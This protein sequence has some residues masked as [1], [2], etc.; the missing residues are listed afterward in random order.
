MDWIPD[1]EKAVYQI[2][3]ALRALEEVILE[4]QI[5]GIKVLEFLLSFNPKSHDQRD[6]AIKIHAIRSMDKNIQPAA[7]TVFEQS[8]SHGVPIWKIYKDRIYK[9][10]DRRR[11]KLKSFSVSCAT[12]FNNN[13][14]EVSHEAENY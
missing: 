14:K 5:E 10:I 1:F 13:S 3:S 6:I 9:M 7:Y 2:N 4:N 12:P 11:E 8:L